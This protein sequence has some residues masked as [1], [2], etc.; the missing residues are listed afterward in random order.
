MNH[1]GGCLVN[2][3]T[4]DPQS[5]SKY[6]HFGGQH[7][8]L[9]ALFEQPVVQKQGMVHLGS[10]LAASNAPLFLF[11]DPLAHV[12]SAPIAVATLLK[13]ELRLLLLQIWNRL[14][15][16]SVLM[17]RSSMAVMCLLNILACPPAWDG[18]LNFSVLSCQCTSWLLVKLLEVQRH[19]C[20]GHA[21]VFQ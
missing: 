2:S 1:A 20:V 11:S 12:P 14:T 13:V 6:Q 3:P 17:H 5:C 19:C 16:C 15:C 18:G 21:A 9:L 10:H 4:A 7:L 8:T